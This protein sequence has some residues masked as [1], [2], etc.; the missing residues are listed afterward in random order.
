MKL[1]FLRSFKITNSFI[2]F[3]P[4][5]LLSLCSFG[6]LGT[7]SVRWVT[8]PPG[9]LLFIKLLIGLYSLLELLLQSTTYWMAQ[10]IRINFPTV[11]ESPRQVWR[12]MRRCYSRPLSGFHTITLSLLTCLQLFV[13]TQR[14]YQLKKKQKIGKSTNF[15]LNL[16]H[17]LKL[18]WG[19]PNSQLI[20]Y[21]CI[22]R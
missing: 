6:C 13:H 18:I 10:T 9:L 15:G 21:A 12:L 17:F 14:W 1:F 22:C 20:K 7:H 11:L 19:S 2:S 4:S 3:L 16:P 5:F 8:P